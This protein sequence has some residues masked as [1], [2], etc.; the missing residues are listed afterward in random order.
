LTEDNKKISIWQRLREKYRISVLDEHTLTEHWYLHLN[1]WGAIVVVAMLFLLALA[2]FS[3]VIL[4]TPIKHYL[5]G[6]SED[7]R[8]ELL[9]ESARVDSLGTS[10]E[11]QR[12]Y[13]NIIKQVVAGEAHTD[14]VQSLDSMQIIMREQLLEAKNEATA[15]YIAQYEAMGKD[16]MQLFSGNRATNAPTMA[17]FTPVHG[18]VI[19]Q[20]SLQEKRYGITIQ[21]LENKNVNAVLNGTVIYLNHEINDVYTVIIKHTNYL[22]IY[23]GLKK[24]LKNPGQ[25]VQTGECIGLTADK[26]IEF[27]LW[28]DEQA[29]DPEQLIVF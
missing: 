20:F 6:Y 17:F 27:E 25:V 13:L 26:N 29:V 28:K 10:L 8:Q 19:S 16:N 14:T 24:S 21:T 18:S 23:R 3:L 12:Q 11:L 15:E 5:P 7:I 4:Y 1:G 22:S 9:I 2:L